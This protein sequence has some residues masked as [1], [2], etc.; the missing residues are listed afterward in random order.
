[1]FREYVGFEKHAASSRRIFSLEGGNNF[2]KNFGL[3]CGSSN[4]R[5]V[6]F[7]ESKMIKLFSFNFIQ[8]LSLDFVELF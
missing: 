2:E 3:R 1:M 7:L 5:G 4:L 6:L 8:F